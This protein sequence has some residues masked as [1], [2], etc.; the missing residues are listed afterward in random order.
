MPALEYE[1]MVG[2]RPFCGWYYDVGKVGDIESVVAPPHDVISDEEREGLY[3]KSEHNAVRV[4]LP[5]DGYDEAKEAL[6][7]MAADGAIKQDDK[8]S[9]YVYE[10]EFDLRGKLTKRAGLMALVEAKP[11]GAGDVL[12]HEMTFPEKVED[13]L[14]VFWK[15]R[16]NLSPVFSLYQGDEEVRRIIDET[17]AGE[18][19]FEFEDSQGIV[20][21]L[22]PI[23]DSEDV[24]DIIQRFKEKK[25]TIAD[26][27][28][29]YT[30]AAK[31]AKLDEAPDSNYV[32]MYLVDIDDPGL[33]VLPTH[34]LLKHKITLDGI[35][36]SASELFD[37]MELDGIHELEEALD[38]NGKYSFGLHTKEKCYLLKLK[39]PAVIELIIADEEGETKKSRDWKHLDVSV[40]RGVIFK[41]L[42]GLSGELD[43]IVTYAKH[44][45]DVIRL[46]DD[47]T[48]DL[49]FLLRHTDVGDVVR[50]VE[51]GEV[52]PHKSTYFWPKPLAGLV[53][54]RM[55]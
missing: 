36:R 34:R 18:P 50:I 38:G 40:L 1:N 5:K 13:R 12:P 54:R 6:D 43:G 7:N 20:N 30:A 28:H 46:I 3:A 15:T 37:I 51:N 23:N 42:L 31:F 32:L 25:V 48:Y 10:Q 55:G 16:A 41:K 8:E 4:I 29:R 47:G 22:W 24:K 35:I 27:H 53:I 49:A 11:F 33:K 21:R 17:R 19:R 26:G 44:K 9:F 2:I 39:D 14:Q 45:D 52:M